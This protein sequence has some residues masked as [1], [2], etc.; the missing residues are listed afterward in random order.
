MVPD[1]VM[2]YMAPPDWPATLSL[3]TTFVSIGLEMP[4]SLLAL[5]MAPPPISA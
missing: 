3:K 4:P 5:T 1:S 2:P